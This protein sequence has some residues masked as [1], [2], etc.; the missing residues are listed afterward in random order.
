MLTETVG[1]LYRSRWYAQWGADILGKLE[2]NTI[3][4]FSSSY[5]TTSLISMLGGDIAGI[6]LVSWCKGLNKRA[7]R[8]IVDVLNAQTLTSQHLYFQSLS[9]TQL[10]TTTNLGHRQQERGSLFWQDGSQ[11]INSWVQLIVSNL[12]I[13]AFHCIQSCQDDCSYWGLE[14]LC[15]SLLSENVDG[16]DSSLRENNNTRCCQLSPSVLHISGEHSWPD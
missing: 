5:I 9:T 14:V 6:Q 11:M 10:P 16:S 1:E 4:T 8:L 2:G 13:S 12:F 15:C 7:D 3:N